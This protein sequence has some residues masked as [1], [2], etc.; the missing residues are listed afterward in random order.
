MTGAKVIAFLRSLPEDERLLAL[1]ALDAATP[2]HALTRRALQALAGVAS[3]DPQV[4]A[5]EA[6]RL[7]DRAISVIGA[8]PVE[9][10]SADLV[11]EA[12]EV[13]AE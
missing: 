7:W 3:G 5:L 6:A 1:E 12:E 9:C 13:I 4:D 8:D 11:A 2:R 10:V